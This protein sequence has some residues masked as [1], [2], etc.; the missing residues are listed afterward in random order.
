MEASNREKCC[1]TGDYDTLSLD[2][3]G[4][5]CVL[6]DYLIREFRELF[7][8]LKKRQIFFGGHPVSITRNSCKEIFELNH[9]RTSP[10]LVCEKSDGVRYLLVVARVLPA[11]AIRAHIEEGEDT[12]TQCY[13]VSRKG[14]TALD[15]SVVDVGISYDI[16]FASS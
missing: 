5:D 8:S 7:P 1:Y 4:I 15:A 14:H 2:Q 3:P 9:N 12:V 10:Y 13:F 16:N 6:P 11:D